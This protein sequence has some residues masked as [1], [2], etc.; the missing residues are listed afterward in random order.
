MV[1]GV[2]LGGADRRLLS[3]LFPILAVSVVSV[4]L[5]GAWAVLAVDPAS[6]LA[7]TGGPGPGLAALHM[8]TLGVLLMT[9]VLVVPQILPVVTMCPTP[10]IAVLAPV[11][12]ALVGGLSALVAG[13]AAV[14]TTWMAAGAVILALG[15]SVFL[16][17][18]GTLLWRARRSGMT[19]LLV[20]NGVAWVFMALVLVLGAA[21]ALDYRWAFLEDH[22]AIARSHALLALHGLM[23]A[24]VMGF[25]TVLIPM[26]AVAE[27]PGRAG[28]RSWILLYAA[29]VAVA[30]TGTA[31]TADVVAWIGWLAVMAAVAG[32]LRVMG[33]VMKRRLRKR[34]GPSFWLIRLSWGLW[35]AGLAAGAAARLDVLPV[36]VAGVLLLPGWL[37][38]LLLGLLQRIVPFLASMHS[39]RLC[40]RPAPLTVFE[41]KSLAMLLGAAHGLAVLALVSGAGLGLDLLIRLAGGLGALSGG[42]LLTLSAGVL[43]RFLFHRRTVGSRG[44]PL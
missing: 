10:P 43:L 18:W 1:T 4:A 14:E 16:V 27:P 13:F 24:L 6:A 36:E 29:G 42:V 44:I 11:H 32:H 19:D 40:A 3:P 38:S 33:A 30:A 39:V 7:V 35:L 8:L 31:L 12:L 20:A 23:G 34:L 21:L 41:R 26:L 5:V 15:L 25:S 9:V 37:L 28:T 2:P 17:L 22:G